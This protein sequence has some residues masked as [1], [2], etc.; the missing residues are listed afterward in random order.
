MAKQV[1]SMRKDAIKE[2]WYF[3]K[4][5]VLFLYFEN[6]DKIRKYKESL[7]VEWEKQKQKEV[8]EDKKK[9]RVWKT[10]ENTKGRKI[11]DK[12]FKAH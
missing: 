2:F 6:K 7:V 8:K 3:R 1:E 11:S 5:W 4:K 9:T 10:V 12:N